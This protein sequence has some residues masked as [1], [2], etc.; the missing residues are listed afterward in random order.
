[1]PKGHLGEQP[2]DFAAQPAGSPPFRPQEPE[3]TAGGGA[4][5]ARIQAGRPWV[6][7]SARPRGDSARTS[8]TTWARSA[9]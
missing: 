1:M 9:S 4:A 8:P 5:Q 6:R 7:T 3:A 2:H